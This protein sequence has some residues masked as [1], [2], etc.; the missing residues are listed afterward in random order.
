MVRE[1]VCILSA[2]LG[3]DRQRVAASALVDCVL[4]HCWC[5]EDEGLGA[6][7]YSG[8]ELARMLCAMAGLG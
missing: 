6:G 7:W 1:R 8:I 2:E 4:S 5:F 3:Y